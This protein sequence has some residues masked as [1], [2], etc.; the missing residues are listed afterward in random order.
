MIS[1]RNF[2]KR[3]SALGVLAA[4][5]GIAACAA[6]AEMAGSAFWMP[7]EADP[8]ERNCIDD[9]ERIAEMEAILEEWRAAHS[10]ND[11][12]QKLDREVWATLQALGYGGE[13]EIDSLPSQKKAAAA[14]AAKKK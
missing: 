13:I 6:P 5:P 3:A 1:P 2:S 4:F 12:D 11:P 14:A 7:E 8:H 9:P 10:P